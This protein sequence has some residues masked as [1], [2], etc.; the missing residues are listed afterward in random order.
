MPPYHLL[1]HTAISTYILTSQNAQP[2][3]GAESVERRM[4][5][6]TRYTI[7]NARRTWKLVITILIDLCVLWVGAAQQIG[8][9]SKCVNI[10]RTTM[11]ENVFKSN[12]MKHKKIDVDNDKNKFTYSVHFYWHLLNC[13]RQQILFFYAMFYDILE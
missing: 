12:K 13:R 11:W 7:Y 6:R 8:L 5:A 10:K 3:L 2:D 4:W 1:I 9:V